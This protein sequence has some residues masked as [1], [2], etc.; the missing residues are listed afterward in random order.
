MFV[1]LRLVAILCLILTA[2]L[3]ATAADKSGAETNSANEAPLVIFN[4]TVVVF[5]SD[6]LGVAPRPGPRAP[7]PRSTMHWRAAENT[8]L[9]SGITP[10]GNW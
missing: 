4:R 7:S 2:A 5:R 6:F 10:K 9:P 3:P 8:M 1:I